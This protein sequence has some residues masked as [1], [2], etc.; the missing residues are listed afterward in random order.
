MVFL[1]LSV[2]FGI[3]QFFVNYIFFKKHFKLEKF[4]LETIG[5][6]SKIEQI[7]KELN[8][9]TEEQEEKM[10]K[11]YEGIVD[12]LVYEKIKEV[13]IKKYPNVLPESSEINIKIQ[14]ILLIFSLVLLIYFMARILF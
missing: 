3:M 4:L 5:N 14:V 12:K 6:D 7:K 1:G 9:Y 11:I 13:A 2:L 8:I 10:N